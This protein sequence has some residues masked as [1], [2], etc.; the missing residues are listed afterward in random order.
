MFG[1]RQG[2]GG[3]MIQGIDERFGINRV[4][5]GCPVY[6]LARRR[7]GME[8][9]RWDVRRIVILLRRGW[10][11][12][13]TQL[14][15]GWSRPWGAVRN[16]PI[17]NRC[18]SEA[19]GVERETNGLRRW[20]STLGN[21]MRCCYHGGHD[22]ASRVERRLCRGQDEWEQRLVELMDSFR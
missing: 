5:L 1:K 21:C 6:S 3:D 11:C 7:N 4:Y 17:G 19:G 2:C 14:F 13:G 16:V 20:G 22:C 9:R 10:R 12:D 18:C 8:N 15:R